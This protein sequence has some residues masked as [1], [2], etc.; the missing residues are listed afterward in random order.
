[1]N[2]ISYVLPPKQGMN[3][4]DELGYRRY[5][6]VMHAMRCRLPVIQGENKCDQLWATGDTGEERIGS[7]VCYRRYRGGMNMISCGLPA[8]QG[9]NE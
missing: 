5:R 3:E 9:R 8:I 6:E 4:C 2:V 7:A 1:M